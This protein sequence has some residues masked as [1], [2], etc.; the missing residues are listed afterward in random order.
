M[1]RIAVAL[2]IHAALLAPAAGTRYA[3]GAQEL[4]PYYF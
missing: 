4:L 2:A 3:L 1:K